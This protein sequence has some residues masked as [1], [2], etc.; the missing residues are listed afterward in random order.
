MME[1]AQQEKL[2]L[3]EE[4]QKR[5]E[6]LTK[7]QQHQATKQGSKLGKVHISRLNCRVAKHSG[8]AFFLLKV[9]DDATEK[10]LYLLQRAY[11]LRQEQE[12][13]VKNVNSLILATKC[14]LIREAQIKEKE[15]SY[16]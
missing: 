12:E 15:V 13:E 3:Q 4:S 14:M 1:K 11:D 2:K 6:A 7:A 8:C 5:K 16:H 9:E 10:N